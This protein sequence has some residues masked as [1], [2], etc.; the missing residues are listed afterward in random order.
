MVCECSW[1]NEKVV[2]IFIIIIIAMVRST[3]YTYIQ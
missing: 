1:V 3:K 2:H